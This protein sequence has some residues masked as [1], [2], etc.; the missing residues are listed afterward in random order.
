MSKS[1][2][3][4]RAGPTSFQN[5]VADRLQLN[6]EGYVPITPA[7]ELPPHLI[8]CLVAGY[9]G[10]YSDGIGHDDMEIR[11]IKGKLSPRIIWHSTCGFV[12]EAVITRGRLKYSGSAGS[13]AHHIVKRW[14]AERE[15]HHQDMHNLKVLTR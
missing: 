14:L 2:N 5:W 1:P 3:I 11:L 9:I 13:Y 4:F 7:T 8:A 10:D 6:G 15:K 12:G